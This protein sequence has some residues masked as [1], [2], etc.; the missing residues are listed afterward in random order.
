MWW[1]LN[2]ERKLLKHSMP[3]AY[4]N[5][6]SYKTGAYIIIDHKLHII[7]VRVSVLSPVLQY[8]VGRALMKYGLCVFLPTSGQTRFLTVPTVR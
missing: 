6:K 2:L 3:I 1:Y 5:I 7:S 8:I 4:A